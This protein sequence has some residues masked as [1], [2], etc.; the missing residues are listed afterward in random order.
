MKI[1]DEY[2]ISDWAHGMCI[3][4][5]EEKYWRLITDSWC[6]CWYCIDIKDRKELWNLITDSDYAFRY[7]HDVMDREE[8]RKY[9]K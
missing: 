5:D 3:K 8:V 9:I 6:I 2:K 7:C 4:K 1:F